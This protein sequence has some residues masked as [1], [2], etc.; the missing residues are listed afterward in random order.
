MTKVVF[1]HPDLGIGG[2]ERLVVDAALALKGKGCDVQ[3]VTSHHSPQHC[4][5]ETR[6]GT[7]PVTV[8]GDWLPRHIFGRFYALCA[9]V[10]MIYAA[11]Y[12]VFFSG[13][14]PDI[15]FCDQVSVCVPF[16]RIGGFKVLFYCHFPDQLLTQP[17]SALKS[18]YR[19]PLNWLEETTTGLA[20]RILVN[21]IFTAG[22][23]RDTF[24]RLHVQ[25][26]VLY[27]TMNTD[28]FDNTTPLP[29]SEILNKEF[30][31]SAVLFLSINRYERK[32]NLKLALDAM[33]ELKNCLSASEWLHVHLVMAGGYDTRVNENVEHYDEL[34]SHANTLGLTEKVTFMKSPSDVEKISLLKHCH[35][36][37]Y[38]PPNEHFGIVPL[39]AMYAGKPVIA[40]NS[41]GPT[42]TVVNDVT[43]FLCNLKPEDFAHAM[44]KCI[45]NEGVRTK[46]GKAGQ[47][48]IKKLFSFM[49][50]SDQLL[51]IVHSLHD[52]KD[53]VE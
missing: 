33:C 22:V 49:A 9:Y 16:L 14:A 36:L 28:V 32:K 8:V 1:L 17:G 37:I 27:P 35:C 42:E 5:V 24:K 2:A 13:L 38:T 12:V 53:K 4:F 6:D 51:E 46:L 20:D 19:A 40:A 31:D 48:R 25:P 29:I 43:G 26:T 3:F 7:L 50:F 44:L 41:G 47:D 23:F 30:A 34:L 39:E 18:F 11:V 45:Q 15:V 10:R 52:M 21:S